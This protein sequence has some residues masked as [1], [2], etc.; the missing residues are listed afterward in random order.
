M[1]QFCSIH[2]IFYSFELFPYYT[3]IIIM[4][5]SLKSL[6]KKYRCSIFIL[7]LGILLP[8]LSSAQGDLLITPKRIVFD[9][10]KRFDEI[11]LANIGKDTV[12]YL[13]SWI[14]IRMEDNGQFIQIPDKDSGQRFSDKNIRLFPRTVTLGPHEAQTVKLQLIK[15]NELTEGEYRSHLF[16]RSIKQNELGEELTEKTDST[17]T[18]KMTPVFGISI[19]VIIRIGDGKVN[20]TLSDI[21]FNLEKDSIPQLKMTFNRTGNI[22][23]YGNVSVDHVSEQ[24]KVTRVGIMKGLSVYTPNSKRSIQMTLEKNPAVNYKTGKLR[25]SYLDQSDKPL[26]LAEKEITL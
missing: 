7:T 9:G 14:Q 6:H 26:K 13:I 16:F 2:F 8:I 24:G 10:T 15:K 1:L 22:S 21:S 11:N 3:Q 17:I 23:C 5:D 19:P 20:V 18:I 12:T 25:I 4:K